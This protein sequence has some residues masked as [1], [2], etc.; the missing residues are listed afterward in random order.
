MKRKSKKIKPVKHFR[1]PFHFFLAWS[2][3]AHML[4]LGP[5]LGGGT[6]NGNGGSG[7][8]PDHTVGSFIPKVPIVDSPITVTHEEIKLDGQKKIKKT[9]KRKKTGKEEE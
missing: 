3:V 6:G 8:E 2:I 9:K 7:S 1:W 5:F 4:I